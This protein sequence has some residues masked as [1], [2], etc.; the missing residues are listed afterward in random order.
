MQMITFFPTI[1]AFWGDSD[2][3]YRLPPIYQIP[4]PSSNEQFTGNHEWNIELRNFGFVF[5][6]ILKEATFSLRNRLVSFIPR[7]KGRLI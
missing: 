6:W 4:V 2:F 3:N 1:V 5:L 7:S